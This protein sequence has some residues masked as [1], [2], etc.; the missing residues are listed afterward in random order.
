MG[1]RSGCWQWTTIA[2]THSGST[3]FRDRQLVDGAQ[4]NGAPPALTGNRMQTAGGCPVERARAKDGSD[5]G[6]QA[7][8]NASNFAAPALGDFWF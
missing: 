5:S 6:R 7:P 4:I 2:K 8:P 3:G 1:A